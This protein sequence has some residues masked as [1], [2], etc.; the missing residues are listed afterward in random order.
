MTPVPAFRRPD[1]RPTGHHALEIPVPGFNVN[2]D[3]VYDSTDKAKGDFGVEPAD[4]LNDGQLQLGSRRPDALL[5]RTP[6]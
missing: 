3:R 1:A 4:E 5:V 2:L 6:A